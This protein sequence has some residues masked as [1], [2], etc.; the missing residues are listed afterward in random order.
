[1]HNAAV[2]I[3][4]DGNGATKGQVGNQPASKWTKMLIHV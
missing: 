3:S 2:F 4:N 1:M